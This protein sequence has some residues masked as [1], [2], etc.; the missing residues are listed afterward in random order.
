MESKESKVKLKY[1]KKKVHIRPPRKGLNHS[2]N[3]FNNSLNASTRMKQTLRSNNKALAHALQVA[4]Q[5]LALATNIISSLRLDNRNLMLEAAS[6]KYVASQGLEEQI[7]ARLKPIL[8]TFKEKVSGISKHIN[9]I[10]TA[11]QDISACASSFLSL[12]NSSLTSTEIGQHLEESPPKKVKEKFSPRKSILNNIPLVKSQNLALSNDLSLIAESF[13]MDNTM[14]VLSKVDEFESETRCKLSE[15]NQALNVPTAKHKTSTNGKRKSTNEIRRQSLDEIDFGTNVTKCRRGRRSSLLVSAPCL[16]NNPLVDLL[17]SAVIKDF[18]PEETDVKV[19]D[20]ETDHA[21]PE[22][23]DTHEDFALAMESTVDPL[24]SVA[25]TMDSYSPTQDMPLPKSP[26]A[27]KRRN[28]RLSR[29]LAKVLTGKT[30]DTVDEFESETRC[31]LSEE[32]QA[33][34]VPTAKHKTSTNGKRKSTNEIRRQSRDE[35]DFGTN[36]T[37]CRR[38]RRSSLLVSAPCLDNNPLVD[39]LDSAVIKD[40]G[41]EETDIKVDDSETDYAGPEVPDTHEDFTAA[42]IDVTPSITAAKTTGEDC[43][44]NAEVDMDLTEITTNA[45]IMN[46][47]CQITPAPGKSLAKEKEVS[48]AKNPVLKL[49]KEKVVPVVKAPVIKSPKVKEV[50]VG[51]AVKSPKVKEVPVTKAVKSPKVKEVPVTKAVKSPKVKELPVAKAPLKEVP[52]VKNPVIKSPKEKSVPVE[53]DSVF[54]SPKVSKKANSQQT[55]KT[56]KVSTDKTDEKVNNKESSDNEPK[57]VIELRLP[58]PGKI[59]FSA[60]RKNFSGIRP[61]PPKG[62]SKRKLNDK[63]SEKEEPKSLFDF[64][65]KTP[66][67]LGTKK[68]SETDGI[69]N[70]SLNDS[71]F[72]KCQNLGQYRERVAIAKE[73]KETSDVSDAKPTVS[74]V[75]SECD[76]EKEEYSQSK[77]TA[78]KDLKKK[79]RS[80]RKTCEI[81][82]SFKLDIKTSVPTSPVKAPVRSRRARSKV[83]SYKEIDES[84][85]TS[86]IKVAAK[87]ETSRSCENVGSGNLDGNCNESETGKITKVNSSKPESQNVAPKRSEVSEPSNSSKT[88]SNESH[89]SHAEN[90][91]ES[92]KTETISSSRSQLSIITDCY[93]KAIADDSSFVPTRKRGR[94]SSRIYRV[95]LADSP[96][97]DSK[98]RPTKIRSRS[99][100]SKAV[101][102][103]GSGSNQADS[104][105]GDSKETRQSRRQSYFEEKNQLKTSTSSRSRRKLSESP[106]KLLGKTVKEKKLCSLNKESE[107]GHKKNSKKG[108]ING[109]NTPT[110]LS[111]LKKLTTSSSDCKENFQWNLSGCFTPEPTTIK[112]PVKRQSD[113]YND[114]CGLKRPRRT[115]LKTISY[116]EPHLNLKLR[117]GDE[118]FRSKDADNEN[119]VCDEIKQ[120]RNALVNLTNLN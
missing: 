26:K 63:A 57:A 86:V 49:P 16:D 93:R 42:T 33:L 24:P 96:T 95:P 22:V 65:D 28:S 1:V 91:T 120:Q 108:E 14:D 18:G 103:T 12:A 100:P 106:D 84:F 54:K 64:H 77:K 88:E 119:D 17:D 35:I 102:D 87:P 114:A 25:A 113:D 37:K 60:T 118:L 32:N 89:S 99:V 111:K 116:R 31:K 9:I 19:D 56:S 92:K 71:T 110:R 78:T 36:V 15:E 40:F 7:S 2:N 109:K 58:K 46:S 55:K 83:T 3:S 21:G 38:G 79:S 8:M 76:V 10:T 41:P 67:L 101:R 23:P 48:V 82:E 66:Q 104:T 5:D 107:D 39:L 59:V 44:I 6:H 51:K 52:V 81:D 80:R 105:D 11:L 90:K 13:N 94:S 43:T 112:P 53:K 62:R 45:S 68:S 117:Q 85:D 115:A 20:S 30:D 72:G 27:S 74:R 98:T 47:S 73:K 70:V 75:S 69:Y 29:T 34:N 61:S 4:K 97:D 50:P